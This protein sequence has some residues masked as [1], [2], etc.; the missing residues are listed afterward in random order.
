MIRIAPAVDVKL[1]KTDINWS[2]PH[3]TP[4]VIP[5]STLTEHFKYRVPTEVSYIRRSV[6]KKDELNK[7]FS[8]QFELRNGIN[9]PIYF[10]V[11]HKERDRA[12]KLLNNVTFYRPTFVSSQGFL[13]QKKL[14]RL[15]LI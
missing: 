5:Q 4:N 3:S 14:Q 8:F 13:L 9:M 10:I 11:R 6:F 7:K 2:A 12:A 15:V 1:L